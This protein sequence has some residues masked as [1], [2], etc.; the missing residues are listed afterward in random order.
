MAIRRGGQS[1]FSARGFTLV[2]LLIVIGILGV[3][4]AMVVSYLVRAKLAANEASAI[5]TLRALSSA[6]TAYSSSCGRNA[7]APTF[8]R[9]V[10]GGYASPDMNLSPKS[11]YVFTLTPGVG[12]AGLPDC[13]LQATQTAFYAGAQPLSALATGRRAF[14]INLGGAIWQNHLG[15]PPAEPF[16][17]TPTNEPIQ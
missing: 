9:L 5:A 2:E 4:A 10:T 14:A 13:E 12:G 15:I 8:A 17:R 1:V 6:Q 7:Y 16:V 11:G 3:L